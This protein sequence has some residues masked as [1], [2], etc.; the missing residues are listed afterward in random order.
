MFQFAYGIPSLYCESS[1]N[2]DLHQ[3]FNKREENFDPYVISGIH[4]TWVQTFVP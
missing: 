2:L 4:D 1:I 3:V